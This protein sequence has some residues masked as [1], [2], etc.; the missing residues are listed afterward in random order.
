[1]R[2][3]ICAA[4][5]ADGFIGRSSDHIATA[6]T[7]DEDKKFFTRITKEAGVIVWGLNTFKTVGRALPGRRTIVYARN[8]EFTPPPGVEV[9]KEAPSDLIKRLEREGATQLAVCG[10]TQ[11]Y[12]MFMKAGIVD[13]LYL[14]VHSVLFGSGLTLFNDDLRNNLRLVSV[15]QLGPD[16]VSIHYTVVD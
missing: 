13:D 11:I 1:M 6:W 5:T 3:F 14:N 15:D 16:T 10:G 12:T 8:S 4:L 9:T 7:S 2:V